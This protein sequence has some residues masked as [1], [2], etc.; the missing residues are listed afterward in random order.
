MEHDATPSTQRYIAF[1]G[2]EGAGKSTVADR[3]AAHLE[4]QGHTVVRVREPGG[5][6]VGEHIRDIL[7]DGEHTPVPRAE[8]ALFAAARAH[9]VAEKVIPALTAGSWVISDRSAYSSL[10]YQAAGRGLALDDIRRLNDIAIGGVWPGVVVLLHT[11]PAIG[12]SRQEVGDRIGN[13]SDA[14]HRTVA[15]AFDA[16]ADAEPDRFTVIDAS[17]SLERVVADV[18]EALG[19]TT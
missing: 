5:T 14:F 6:A 9:L 10:A 12:L 19:V 3:V 4:A 18:L 1:E 7:L 13:E 8:A 2:V 16:L 11:D 17:R 15:E